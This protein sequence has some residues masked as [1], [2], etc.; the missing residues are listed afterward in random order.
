MDKTIPFYLVFVFGEIL[1]K[2]TLKHLKL[3]YSV[4]LH[5]KS[6]MDLVNSLDPV[7][8]DSKQVI[9]LFSKNKSTGPVTII[10]SCLVICLGHLRNSKQF[11]M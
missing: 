4:F 5:L 8:N 10:F 6:C 9:S 2:K 7:D 1:R 3:S 11:S